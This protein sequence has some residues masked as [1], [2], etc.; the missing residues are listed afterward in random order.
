MSAYKQINL[1]PNRPVLI[2]LVKHIM[3]VKCSPV[4]TTIDF[5]NQVYANK[6]VNNYIDS[7][8]YHIQKENI[9]GLTTYHVGLPICVVILIDH[10]ERERIYFNPSIT[11][12]SFKLFDSS[13]ENDIICE[14]KVSSK[15]KRYFRID[16]EYSEVDQ[17][18]FRG[19]GK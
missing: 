12:Y 5:G 18:Y 17:N 6:S 14:E 2:P 9:T 15:K 11:N 19:I 3:N 7:V 1:D 13:H 8:R 4:N 10:L 16:V